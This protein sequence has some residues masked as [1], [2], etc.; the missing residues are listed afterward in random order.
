MEI[1]FL[2]LNSFPAG[3]FRLLASGHVFTN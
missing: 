1:P 2:F 3:K